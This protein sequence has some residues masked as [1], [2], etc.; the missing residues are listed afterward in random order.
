MPG[1]ASV[2]SIFS[3]S[4]ALWTI[5]G[6]IAQM[7]NINCED[8]LIV[9]Y[10]VERKEHV[11]FFCLRLTRN[12]MKKN[13]YHGLSP[14]MVL[15]DAYHHQ[16]AGCAAV[17][18]ASRQVRSNPCN[19]RWVQV[20]LSTLKARQQIKIDMDSANTR[21]I[22]WPCWR[23][24]R[25]AGASTDGSVW[26]SKLIPNDPMQLGCWQHLVCRFP[27]PNWFP[28]WAQESACVRCPLRW[29]RR[30]RMLWPCPDQWSRLP[31]VARMWWIW[32][33]G[34]PGK[35]AKSLPSDKTQIPALHI[36]KLSMKS[37]QHGEDDQKRWGWKTSCC[38]QIW[39]CLKIV[40]KS[41]KI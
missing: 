33:T 9:N 15:Y 19:I 2:I 39:V 28:S 32:R 38:F 10:A 34:W 12:R 35:P 14:A 17:R 6:N 36:F 5:Q 24:G 27:I 41:M 11:I 40:G 7:W 31:W 22:N 8:D 26:R 37:S 16:W 3:E 29:R 4:R 18:D 25:G 20:G 1:H 13:I 23:L 30:L 21:A